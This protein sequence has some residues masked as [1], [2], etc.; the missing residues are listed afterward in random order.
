[1]SRPI[2]PQTRQRLSEAGRR[3][4]DRRAILRS[5]QSPGERYPQRYA[6]E[7]LILEAVAD[8]PVPEPQIRQAVVAAGISERTYE[9]A[10]GELKRTCRLRT[11]RHGGFAAAGHW[12][13]QLEDG[14]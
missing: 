3:G 8:G 5:E 12:V 11:T 13:L 2:S 7:L 14:P 1:M 4:A 6:A 10:R 9:S